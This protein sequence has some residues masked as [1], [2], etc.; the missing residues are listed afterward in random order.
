LHP[1]Q[2][3]PAFATSWLAEGGDENELVLVAGWRSRI[4]IDRSTKATAVVRARA[5]H[6]RLSPGD[7]L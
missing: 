5:S 7:R 1:H 3:R 4:M 6:A 2:L